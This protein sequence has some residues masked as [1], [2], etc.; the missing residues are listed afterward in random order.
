MNLLRSVFGEVASMFAG[1]LGLTL[2]LLAIVATAVAL[3]VL[4]PFPPLGVAAVLLVG[5]AGV[6]AYRV[7]AHARK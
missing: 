4:T 2:A 3:R 7:V 6:I 1:D 5:C